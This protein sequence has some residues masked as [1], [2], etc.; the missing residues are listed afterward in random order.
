MRC[1][2]YINGYRVVYKNDYALWDKCYRDAT[3]AGVKA[4]FMQL[5]PGTSLGD[6][7]K[8]MLVLTG[9]RVDPQIITDVYNEYHKEIVT[10]ED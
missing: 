10:Y 6:F 2:G 8:G 9:G 4:C 3:R 7:M 5:P 1:E